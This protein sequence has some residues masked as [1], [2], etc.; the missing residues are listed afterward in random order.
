[1][2]TILTTVSKHKNGTTGQ[3]CIKAFDLLRQVL[4][5]YAQHI[6]PLH[7]SSPLLFPNSKGKPL[8]HLSRSVQQLAAKHGLTVPT[9]T[10]ARH[11]AATIAAEK[12]T[13]HKREAVATQ[14]LHCQKEK[15]K[16]VSEGVPS[17]YQTHR[18]Q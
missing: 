17:A 7:V 2:T 12:C 9:A 8:D 14:Q 15:H 1:M 4:L 11:V 16:R 3:A 10:K 5:D 13:A 18:R 6:H